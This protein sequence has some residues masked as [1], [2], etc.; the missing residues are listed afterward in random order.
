MVEGRLSLEKTVYGKNTIWF[1][2]F[3]GISCSASILAAARRKSMDKETILSAV[4]QYCQEHHAKAPYQSGD[5][6][7]YADELCTLVDAA[8][9]FWLTAGDYTRQFEQGLAAYLEVPFCSMVNRSRRLLL[10]GVSAGKGL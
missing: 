9:N 3:Q 10:G 8:L 4:Q 6:I 2:K 7:N 5:R 1:D